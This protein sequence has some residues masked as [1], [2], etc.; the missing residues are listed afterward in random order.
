MAR[1]GWAVPSPTM[2]CLVTM[3]PAKQRRHLGRLSSWFDGSVLLSVTVL[4]VSSESGTKDGTHAST[5]S[6][7]T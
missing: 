5:Y 3:E 6:K 2:T 4:V 1:R 7:G